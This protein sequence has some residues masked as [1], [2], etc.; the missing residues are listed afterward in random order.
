MPISPDSALCW[1]FLLGLHPLLQSAGG[2]LSWKVR[3]A[4]RHSGRDAGHE[5]SGL[6]VSS[7]PLATRAASSLGGLGGLGARNQEEKKCELPGDRAGAWLAQ[8]HF[9]TFFWSKQVKRPPDTSGGEINST[10]RSSKGL[11][12]GGV[13]G[14]S[15]ETTCHTALGS[16]A[17]TGLDF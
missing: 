1:E 3:R 16:Q 10:R 5:A 17:W 13:Q 4:S 2:L 11:S 14:R 9:H 7:H 6:H 12:P 8:C 15:E